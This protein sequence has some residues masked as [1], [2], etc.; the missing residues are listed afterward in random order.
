MVDD[1]TVRS[2]SPATQRCHLHAVEPLPNESYGER[3]RCLTGELPTS[4]PM[5]QTDAG[6]RA[7]MMQ[8][9][10]TEIAHVS[11]RCKPAH[12]PMSELAGYHFSRQ[13]ACGPGRTR[14]RR[15]ARRQ[16]AIL[17]AYRAF[18]RR[19]AAD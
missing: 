8:Q 4:V 2:L 18:R 6:A 15:L 12:K 7:A 19:L 10:M 5:W 11:P 14:C 3:H 16:D 1:M 13:A 17:V 9:L